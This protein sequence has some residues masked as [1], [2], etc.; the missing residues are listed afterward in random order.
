PE[1]EV[2]RWSLIGGISATV[3]AGVQVEVAG[4]SLLGGRS[5]RLPAPGPGAPVLRL[6]L[7]SV[8]GGISVK[9]R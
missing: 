3:P 8:I 1:V 5:V 9:A 2:T 6:R 4:F 7:F